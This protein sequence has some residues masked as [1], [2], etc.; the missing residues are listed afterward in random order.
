MTSTLHQFPPKLLTRI[1]AIYPPQTIQSPLNY[2]QVCSRWRSVAYSSPEL[3]TAL[4]IEYPPALETESDAAYFEAALTSWVLRCSDLSMDLSFLGRYFR[5]TW[6]RPSQFQITVYV[7]ICNKLLVDFSNKWR[8]LKAP[9]F[10]SAHFFPSSL[11][12]FAALEELELGVGNCSPPKNDHTPF[13]KT[14][15]LF[16]L[17]LNLSRILR[18]HCIKNFIPGTVR[19]L[20]MTSA[21]G[22]IGISGDFAIE[23]LQPKRLQ[24]LTHMDISQFGWTTPHVLPSIT[25][26]QLQQLTLGGTITALGDVLGVFT[27]PSL[28]KLSLS[29]SRFD[30]NGEHGPVVGPA[31]IALLKRSY[32]DQCGLVALSLTSMLASDNSNQAISLEDLHRILSLTSTI[33]EL[34]ICSEGYTYT[35]RLMEILRYNRVSPEKQILPLLT[36]FSIESL[37]NLDQNFL[38]FVHSRWWPDNSSPRMVGVAKLEKLIV[39]YCDL[40]EEIEDQLDTCSEGGLEVEIDVESGSEQSSTS[41]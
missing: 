34:H 30:G 33:K 16:K 14:P 15:R 4:V 8:R 6:D 25:L 29:T 20:T 2:T 28:M 11:E 1:F 9:Y 23:F 12:Q 26:P 27:L 21:S 38:D 17:S 10:W 37:F 7:T 31:L 36:T 35:A 13:P 5:N 19:D 22:P 3:W 32:H 39:S 18:F 24:H 40:T 41:E